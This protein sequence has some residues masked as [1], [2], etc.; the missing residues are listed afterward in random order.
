M[1]SMT[2]LRQH[3]H[4]DVLD[5]VERT[6]ELSLER[7]SGVYGNHG[8]T[9]GFRTDQGTWLR[10]QWRS[11]DE[12]H[13]QSWTGTECASVLTSVAKPELMRAFRWQDRERGV[14]WR[15]EEMTLITAPIISASGSITDDPGL[16]DAWWKDLASSLGALAGHRTE[17]VCMSQDH[18]SRRIAEVFGETVNT[19]IGEWTTAHGDLHW[20]NVTAP[21]LCLL[22]W[23]DWGRGPRGLDAA[24]LWGFSL[25]V[26]EVAGRVQRE[27]AEDLQ[28]RSGK[29]AQLL[30][31]ANVLRAHARSG[32]T[33]PFTEPAQEASGRLVAEL[34]S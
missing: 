28:S 7:S 13:G 3:P 15:A 14:V 16:A 34:S 33:M 26:P 11:A 2:D 32:K 24:T 31:C 18:L 8:G 12:I 25:G 19:A 6:L 4:D 17:R 23:E 30:F 21:E 9:A 22:D 20:G 5:L 10:L 29:V 1:G 27:F